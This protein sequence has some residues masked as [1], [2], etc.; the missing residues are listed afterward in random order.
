VISRRDSGLFVAERTPDTHDVEAALNRLDHPIAG[1]LF[2][3]REVD[4]RHGCFVH[5]VMIDNGDQEPA[6]LCEWRDG[7]GRPLP[8]SHGLVDKVRRQ[9]HARD[10]E[11]L[12]AE[13]AASNH[14]HQERL[15]Q[16]MNDAL[17]EIAADVGKRI[18]ETRSPALHRG[19]HLRRSHEKRVRTGEA[20][21]RERLADRL[22]SK[23]G[24]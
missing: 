17:D 4:R 23:E 22:F 24:D 14:T 11:R 13:M 19:P 6:N 16:D 8:L 21:R 1:R 9:M 15:R 7:L 20:A 12:V 3:T 18:S 10:G 5:R 2:I